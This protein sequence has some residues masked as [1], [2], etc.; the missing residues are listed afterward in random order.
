MCACLCVCVC[1]HMHKCSCVCAVEARG[2]SDAIISQEYAEPPEIGRNQKKSSPEVFRKKANLQP[3]GWALAYSRDGKE[4]VSVVFK[5]SSN[6]SS[7]IL[8]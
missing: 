5:A 7:D 8:E 2:W 3:L 4:E 6:S 1:V